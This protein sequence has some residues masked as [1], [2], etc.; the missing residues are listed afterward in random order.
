MDVEIKLLEE[1]FI[2]QTSSG[3][4]RIVTTSGTITSNIVDIWGNEATSLSIQKYFK[5]SLVATRNSLYKL[6]NP[7]LLSR[8]GT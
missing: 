4:Y 6:G 3:H 2:Q 7:A 1:W 8:T 5:N